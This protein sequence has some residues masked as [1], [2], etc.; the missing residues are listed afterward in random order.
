MSKNGKIALLSALGLLGTLSVLLWVPRI[1]QDPAYHH[2]ADLRA[3]WGIPNAMNVLSN[4]FLVLVGILGMNSCWR[5]SR[6]HFR[7]LKGVFFTAVTLTGFGSMTYHWL[8]SN[9]TLVWDRAPMAVMFM[10][11]CL[12]IMADRISYSLASKLLWP[13]AAM[14]VLS[15]V[16]WWMSELR[17]EGDLRLY[18][19]VAFLPLALIPVTIALLPNGTIKNGSI[20]LAICWYA[21]A[22]LFELLDKPIYDWTGIVS[23]H[24]LKHVCAAVAIYC[25]FRKSPKP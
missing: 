15:V 19:I 25:L 10:T 13:M 21:L 24:T 3:F 20:W 8:P 14:G 17:G 23:G 4:I 18:G 12:I 6:T 16:Y 1:P 7:K 22:K 9:D 11:L 2:F 5:K